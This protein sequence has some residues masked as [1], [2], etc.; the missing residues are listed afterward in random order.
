MSTLPIASQ[1]V[2]E[3]VQG[4]SESVAWLCV[5]LFSLTDRH[6]AHAAHGRRRR[7]GA[8]RGDRDEADVL[9][10]LALRGLVGPDGAQAGVLT[11]GAAVRLERHAGEAGELAENVLEGGDEL[12]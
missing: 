6:D 5:W 4:R 3:G 12:V 9:L 1:A 7:V 8:V 11:R 2:G 10:A